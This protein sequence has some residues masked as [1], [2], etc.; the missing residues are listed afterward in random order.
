VKL[1]VGLG[2]PGPRYAATRH[3]VGF[4]VVERFAATR[5]IAFDEARFGG[6]FGCGVLFH[7]EHEGATR[8]ALLEPETWMNRSGEAVAEAWEELGLQDPADLLVAYDDVDL[9]FGRL[10]LRPRGGAGGH[11]GVED[12]IAC[13]AS[14]EFPR[15]RFGVGRPDDERVATTDY[16]LQPFS[17]EEERA[18]GG[19]LDRAA[20]ALEVALTEGL[21]AAMN[22]FNRDPLSG[23]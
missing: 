1:V 21:A 15:L 12:I 4:R 18:L 14:Q 10:R 9:P 5:G 3:N 16:V 17:A 19:H 8:V 7:G 13:L 6:R 2:N 20:E 23:S 22:A 11:R